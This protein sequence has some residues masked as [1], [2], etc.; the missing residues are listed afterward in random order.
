VEQERDVGIL[1]IQ[2]LGEDFV[3]R[4]GDG[5]ERG[6]RKGEGRGGERGG[7]GRRGEERR[8]KSR[9]R[10]ERLFCCVLSK[11]KRRQGY[12]WWKRGMVWGKG[13][14]LQANAEVSLTSEVPVT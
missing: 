5:E 12:V 9:K 13:M 11:R 3:W 14:S 1:T 10:R 4:A 6:E 2:S 7:E 8:G